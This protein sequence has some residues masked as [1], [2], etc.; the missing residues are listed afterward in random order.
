VIPISLSQ[1]FAL[2]IDPRSNR[3]VVVDQN[4][5]RILILPLPR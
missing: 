3:A 2:A 1:Q 4:N 5:N